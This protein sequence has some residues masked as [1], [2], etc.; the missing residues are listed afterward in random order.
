MASMQ[1]W[2]HRRKVKEVQARLLGMLY[3]LAK[4]VQSR[5]YFPFI[6]ASSIRWL[7][8]AEC[9][10]GVVP[11]VQ[12]PRASAAALWVTPTSQG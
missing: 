2:T 5:C 7:R 9:A 11:H 4:D 10:Y 1:A 3:S 12:M 8:H 6:T